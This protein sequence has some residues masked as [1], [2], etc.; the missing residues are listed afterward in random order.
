MASFMRGDP[1][2][3]RRFPSTLHLPDYSPDELSQIVRARAASY[4]EMKLGDG[5]EKKLVEALKTR[6]HNDIK[7][8]NAG[9]AVKLVEQA[10]SRLANRVSKETERRQE[11]LP[12]AAASLSSAVHE[13]QDLTLTDAD[14]D[15]ED[16]LE[17]S[18]AGE[19]AGSDMDMEAKSENEPSEKQKLAIERAQARKDAL[20]ML[21]S[22]EG[23]ENAKA[24]VKKILLKVKL[25]EKG[26]NRAL[27]ETCSNLVLTGN[28]GC[29]KTS[30]AR[31]FHRVLYTH[32]VVRSDSF[33]EKNALELKGAYVGQTT[34]RV[35]NAMAA[36]KGGTIFLDEFPALAAKSSSSGRDSF[37]NDAVR[38]LL[39]EIENNR[40]DVCVI[41][42]G[43]AAP[44]ESALDA[45]PGLRRRFPLRLH[46][47]DYDSHVLARIGA[48]Y[49]ESRFSL[50]LGKGVEG[51]LAKRIATC[52]KQEMEQQNASLPIRLIELAIERMAERVLGD[53]TSDDSSTGTDEEEMDSSMEGDSDKEEGKA[54][55][56]TLMCD[57]FL[58]D[59]AVAC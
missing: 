59:Q 39:T 40:G 13:V 55:F 4:Y 23:M 21:E 42:A 49:A 50:A 18:T 45:D 16:H 25:V 33:V 44:M 30:F 6:Y 15:L 56:Q 3:P 31:I 34:P 52:H 53:D 14:F 10:V 22:M 46:L 57:D 26:A 43:Y 1:G 32:G 19:G 51:F 36:A 11:E 47:Q 9:L 12:S 8:S 28:P 5:V 27:L 35:L 7:G 41:L 2:L 48:R 29:G 20:G 58:V 37:A 17:S 24:F 54:F 38:T